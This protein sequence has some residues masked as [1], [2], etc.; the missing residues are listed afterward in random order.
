M[1]TLDKNQT[2]PS[3][4]HASH[5]SPPHFL[6]I[7]T[8]LISVAVISCISYLMYEKYQLA[9][10]LQSLKN[11]MQSLAQQQTQTINTLHTNLQTIIPEQI[12][13]QE[14]L[15]ATNA[16]V[17]RALQ[18]S[19]YQSNDWL[20][21]KARYCLELAAINQRWSNNS[22]TTIA[23]LQQADHLLMNIHDAELY[24]LRQAIAQEISLINTTSSVDTVGILSKIDAVQQLLI[25]LPIK[26]AFAPTPALSPKNTTD[27]ASSSIWQAQV[28]KSVALLKKLVVIRHHNE[29]IE[30]LVSPEYESILRENCILNLQEAQWAVIQQNP[31]VFTLALNQAINTIVRTFDLNDSNTTLILKQLN[32]LK[33]VELTTKKTPPG[34]ALSLLNQ[35]IDRKESI[36]PVKPVTSIEGPQS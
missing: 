32:A 22:S 24:P 6:Q 3:S 12:Q 30:P 5:H 8:A 2:P 17:T 9:H 11:E 13:L 28:Q 4:P 25:K 18:E 23:L 14:K 16:S 1:T 31:E 15:N 10:S 19:R 34:E 27:S 21:L 35:I 26:N 36:P 7:I 29:N 20:L 33:E